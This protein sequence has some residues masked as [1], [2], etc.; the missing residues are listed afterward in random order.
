MTHDWHPA[1]TRQNASF[2][3]MAAVRHSTG[4]DIHVCTQACLGPSHGYV[5]C[6]QEEG[7][8]WGGG[9]T[10][11]WSKTVRQGF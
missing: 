10:Q 6:F 7:W 1:D 5:L 4:A 11:R 9:V 8:G 3:C 2:I